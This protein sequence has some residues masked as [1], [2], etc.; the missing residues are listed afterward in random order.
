[1]IL[2]RE[3][4]YPP[5]EA[6][7]TA[8]VRHKPKR[9]WK[10]GWRRDKAGLMPLCDAGIL[11]R[12]SNLDRVKMG[13]SRPDP[14]VDWFRMPDPDGVERALDELHVTLDEPL[15]QE[16]ITEGGPFLD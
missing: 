4:G 13:G 14:S 3:G 15:E 1:M 6:R 2:A 11:T 8:A 10:R 5:S 12:L 16:V 9:K 7:F